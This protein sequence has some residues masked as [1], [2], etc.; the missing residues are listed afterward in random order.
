GKAG[1]AV[2]VAQRRLEAVIARLSRFQRVD[3]K[4]FEA[5]SAISEFN[6][7]AYEL[8]AQPLIQSMSNEMTAKLA[9]QYHPLRFQRWAFSDLNP[10]LAWL[11]PAAQAVKA[12]RSPGA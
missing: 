10:W 2:D 1:H 6:Q 9:R 4:P 7:R 12:Q 8:F 11:G 5:V 3:E